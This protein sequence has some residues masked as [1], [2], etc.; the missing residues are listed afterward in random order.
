MQIIYPEQLE[1]ANPTKSIWVTANAGTG[2][3]KILTDRLLRLLLAGN[4]PSHILCISFTKTAAAEIYE[5]VM[6]KITDWILM[7]DDLLIDD[8]T[9]LFGHAPTENEVAIAKHLYLD[10]INSNEE[11]NIKTIHSFCQSLLTNFPL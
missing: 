4:K 3:T 8:L 11:L 2:K 5:R 1:A 7:N 10:I 6:H 9:K